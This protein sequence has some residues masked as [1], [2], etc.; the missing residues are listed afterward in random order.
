MA[1]GALHT[2]VNSGQLCVYHPDSVSPYNLTLARHLLDREPTQVNYCL[3]KCTVYIRFALGVHSLMGTLLPALFQVHTEK[4]RCP[5]EA[6]CLS[7][8]LPEPSL[9]YFTA[10]CTDGAERPISKMGRDWGPHPWAHR[11]ALLQCGPYNSCLS[12]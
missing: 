1:Y 3:L 12:M 4:L 7:T 8:T 9:L 6:V 10:V 11:L 2:I 5:A